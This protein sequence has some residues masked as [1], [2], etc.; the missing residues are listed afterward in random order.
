MKRSLLVLSLPL[1]LLSHLQTY[2]QA[3]NDTCSG[4]ITLT[5]GTTCTNTLVVKDGSVFNSSIP[6][7]GCAT[8]VGADLWYKLVMPTTGAVRIETDVS[9]GSITDGGMAVYI[10]ADCNNL[11]LFKCNNDGNLNSTEKFERINVQQ[12]AGT[13]IYIRVWERNGV[14]AGSFNLCAVETIPSN[15]INDECIGAIELTV[16][17]NCSN[18]L[19]VKDGT[20]TDSGIPNPGCS[21]YVGG[22]LWYKLVMPAT[23]AVRI[24][25]DVSDG[26]ITDGGMAIYVGTDC[27]NLTLLDCNDDGNFSSSEWFEAIS[28]IQPVGSTIYVRVW[29]RNGVGAGSFNLCA[30]EITIH[31]PATNDDCIDAIE[32]LVNTTCTPIIGTNVGA[33]NSSDTDSTIPVPDCRYFIANRAKN[34][35]WFKLIVP[36]SGNLEVQTY[37]DD[38]LIT[39]GV[40]S[41]YSGTCDPNGLTLI[42]CNDDGGTISSPY[43][44]R[45]QLINQ[46]P[47]DT[48]YVRVWASNVEESGTF[49]ICATEVILPPPATNDDCIDAIE[50]TIGATCTPIIGTN[51]GAT[52]SEDFDPTIP[53]P[54]CSNYAGADVW[55]KVVVPTSGNLEIE[56]YEDDFAILDGGLAVYSGTCDSGGLSLLR[57]DSNGGLISYEFERIQIL[58]R[59]SGETLFIRVWSNNNFEAGTFNICASETIPPPPP[60]N[61]DCSGAIELIVADYCSNTTSTF[62]TN[63]GATPSENA[64]STIPDPGCAAYAGGDIWYKTI[65]PSSGN[66]AIETWIYNFTVTDGGMAIYTGDCNSNGLTLLVC[67]NNNGIVSPN[68]ELIEL[69]GQTPGETLYIRIWSYNNIEVGTFS[70]CVSKFTPVAT[71]DDCIEAI[72]LIV[73]NSTPNLVTTYFATPSWDSDQTIPD[74]SC[75]P[76]SRDVWFKVVVPPSGDLAVETYEHDLTISSAAM[77]IY[78][79]NCNPNGLTELACDDNSGI[80]NSNFGRIELFGQTPG[81]FLYIRVWSQSS[82]EIGTFYIVSEELNALA[83]EDNEINNFTMYPNPTK[84][85]VNINFNK[86]LNENISIRVFDIKGKLI[87]SKKSLNLNNDSSLDI[88][89]LENGMYFV[90]LKNGQQETTRKLIVK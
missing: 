35:V 23:G 26:S 9:D 69:L 87:L 50:L 27:N 11:T 10:G 33:T 29:E 68:F 78:S 82:L 80:I 70:I 6:N 28:V 72:D 7:P 60:A 39:D 15:T 76:L 8:Y 34:D 19:V 46:T 47:G 48:L 75:T 77:T 79:G 31:P 84:D 59:T 38:L 51:S 4:A 58:N 86:A 64:D 81:D 3:V 41:I 45:I 74:P 12:L 42:R 20:E 52:N 44:E 1:F 83:V 89:N 22:D 53:D 32:L 61:D 21:G 16:G 67:A 85:L 90:K 71:N 66:L 13:T 57:C 63:L 54:G 36:P 40:M 43:F 5:V 62:A 65:V 14:G 49:N 88:S 24:E 73:D 25:T 2:A 17:V 56:T 37:Q 30:F 18:T 55:F